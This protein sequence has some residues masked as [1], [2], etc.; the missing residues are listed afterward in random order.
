MTKLVRESI[1]E[2]YTEKSDPIKDM[3]ISATEEEVW[4]NELVSQL[5]N[6]KVTEFG[7]SLPIENI[8]IN[9]FYRGAV[10]VTGSVQVGNVLFKLYFGLRDNRR[11]DDPNPKLEAEIAINSPVKR[12]IFSV[13]ATGKNTTPPM[14]I[15]KM[16]DIFNLKFKR[17]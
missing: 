1:N 17:R 11:W 5:E 7:G 14:L 12:G 3:S 8:K 13:K 6:H 15:K 10:D 16:S 4:A 9:Y 2:K